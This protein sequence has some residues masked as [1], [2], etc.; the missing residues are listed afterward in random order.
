MLLIRK[1]SPKTIASSKESNRQIPDEEKQ[2]IIQLLHKN[3]QDFTPTFATEKLEE[4]HKI[5]RDPKTIR[6]IMI[7]EKLW[8]PKQKKKEKHREWRQRRASYGEMIQYDGSY[9][10]WF[11]DRG[12]KCCLLASIDDATSEVNAIFDEH[13]G[14]FPTF[15][16]WREYAKNKGKPYSIYV[17]KF[18]TYSMNHKLA[19]ENDDTLTQFQRAM[20]E[21]NIVQKHPKQFRVNF[22]T[23]LINNEKI[24]RDFEEKALR[25]VGQRPY[26]SAR[27]ICEVIRWETILTQ[28]DDE[29]E[30]F[31]LSNHLSADLGRLFMLMYPQYGPMVRSDNQVIP[32]FFRT[33]STSKRASV[34]RAVSLAG[35]M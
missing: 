19:K 2:K 22:G 1:I 9:E 17:D 10:Y 8:K 13:E 26:Y 7:D 21:L 3:Y 12:K 14:V 15:N 30:T 24:W 33:R 18:S 31:K 34:T 5:K 11:E 25:V 35:A 32:G 4:K 20:K 6:K 29:A 16:F 28:R 27:A 23:W